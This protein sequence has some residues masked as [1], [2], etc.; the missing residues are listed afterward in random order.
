MPINSSLQPITLQTWLYAIACEND[1][2][3][4]A[5]THDLTKDVAL[6]MQGHGSPY[7]RAHRPMS[8]TH[9][10]TDIQ[11]RKTEDDARALADELRETGKGVFCECDAPDSVL[12]ATFRMR[13]H[14]VTIKASLYEL[15]VLP[16]PGCDYNGSY[17]GVSNHMSMRGQQHRDGTGSNFTAA[18][19]ITGKIL[20]WQFDCGDTKQAIKQAENNKTQQTMQALNTY[21]GEDAWKSV[22][23]GDYCN[24][25]PAKFKKRP[26]LGRSAPTGRRAAFLLETH[27]AI[28]K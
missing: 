15:E 26:R 18:H 8:V 4:V 11:S 2:V 22:R 10:Q 7:T 27:I 1:H 20:S 6:H 5:L 3:Y 19:G 21:F 16:I 23:G 28:C 9:V 13:L 14:D 17:I 25:D 24:L 12:A